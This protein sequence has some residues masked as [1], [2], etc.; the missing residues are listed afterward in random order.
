MKLFITKYALTDGIIEIDSS[1]LR[2]KITH[3]YGK[4][5][6]RAPM[7]YYKKAEVFD[8]IK[9]AKTKAET[10]RI[11]KV[12]ALQKQIEKLNGFSFEK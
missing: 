2:D 6:S 10:M 12:T 3:Y 9:D 7:V 8:N 5:G 11:K 4:V 1:I